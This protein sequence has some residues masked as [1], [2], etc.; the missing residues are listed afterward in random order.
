MKNSIIIILAAILIIAGCHRQGAIKPS[1][2]MVQSGN[3]GKTVGSQ[4]EAR[5]IDTASG[6]RIVYDSTV[7]RG[8]SSVRSDGL[9]QQRQYQRNSDVGD[10]Y[11]C[12]SIG[13]RNDAEAIRT[14]DLNINIVDHRSRSNAISPDSGTV[15][16]STE[17][18][19]S[20][21]KEKSDN[22]KIIVGLFLGLASAI[23]LF[24]THK[25]Q[26]DRLYGSVR[27]IAE[28]IDVDDNGKVSLDE[29]KAYI[30]SK[31]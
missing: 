3:L 25:K 24:I 17:N 26:L 27:T 4:P 8:G 9:E 30:K 6:N 5:N 14:I 31:I 15:L 20:T 12:N 29:V 1:K 16:D 7:R 11:G 19:E 28:D 13:V 18:K 10:N 2:E 21:E 22:W 23:Y